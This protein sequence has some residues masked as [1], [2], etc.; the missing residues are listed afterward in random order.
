M[1]EGAALVSWGMG[2]WVTPEGVNR[3][4]PYAGL[5]S[6]GVSR[7]PRSSRVGENG[8]GGNR[9]SPLLICKNPPAGDSLDG[10]MFVLEK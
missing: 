1:D 3:A 5:G 7:N 8:M 9:N 4:T 2:L 10:G 6:R